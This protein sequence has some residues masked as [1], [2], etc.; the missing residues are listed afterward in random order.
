MSK[1]EKYGKLFMIKDLAKRVSELEKKHDALKK[2]YFEHADLRA[3]YKD[4]ASTR[5]N[6]KKLMNLLKREF[7]FESDIDMPVE[8]EKL[9][10]KLDGSITEKKE[11]LSCNAEITS[12][13]DLY[14]EECYNCR[15]K[16][17]EKEL[18]VE[19]IVYVSSRGTSKY[20]LV[21]E[22]VI[23]FLENH[24]PTH[25]IV[26][27]EDLEYLIQL[28]DDENLDYMDF[29]KRIKEEYGIK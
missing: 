4:L 28:I 18:G 3:V 6:L 29:V 13:I 10:E 17:S 8:L 12:K 21:L 25:K 26:K 27:R 2:V 16:D 23:T 19:E 20:R 1:D 11:C 14:Y 15:T 9:L 7:N 5:D 22:G 24:F